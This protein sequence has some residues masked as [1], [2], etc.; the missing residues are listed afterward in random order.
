MNTTPRYLL[1]KELIPVS[2]R[3]KARV[4]GRWIAGITGS[5]PLGE[6]DVCLLFIVCCE[7][8][9]FCDELITRSGE[10][11]RERERETECVCV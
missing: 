1:R 5:N 9:S 4:R 11:Y 3:S 10:S 7:G 2:D 6:V 8:R